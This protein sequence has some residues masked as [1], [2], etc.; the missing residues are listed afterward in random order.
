[1]RVVPYISSPTNNSMAILPQIIVFGQLNQQQQA[2]KNPYNQRE[3]PR[4]AYRG[5]NERKFPARF[6]IQDGKA[7]AYLTDVTDKGYALYE[8]EPEQEQDPYNQLG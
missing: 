3:V 6:P 4:D 1:M 8:T 5:P 7:H 2:S